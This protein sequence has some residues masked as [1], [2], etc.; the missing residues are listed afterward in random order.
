[1]KGTLLEFNICM[2]GGGEVDTHVNTAGNKQVKVC[3]PG[4]ASCT[5]EKGV[6]SCKLNTCG[7]YVVGHLN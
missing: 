7:C 6:I 5:E 1:M 3:S 4:Q 2:Y